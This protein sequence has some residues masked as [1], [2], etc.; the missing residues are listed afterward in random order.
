[1]KQNTNKLATKSIKTQLEENQEGKRDM[2][3]IGQLILILFALGVAVACYEDY[4]KSK[5]PKD[6]YDFI[7]FKID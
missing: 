4:K 3:D 6:T 5:S 2:L 1:M 7:S